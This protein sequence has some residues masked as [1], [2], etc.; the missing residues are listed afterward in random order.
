MDRY[1]A[2]PPSFEIELLEDCSGRPELLN[3]RLYWLHSA[4]KRPGSGEPP[5]LELTSAS[6]DGRDRKVIADLLNSPDWLPEGRLLGAHWGRAYCLLTRQPRQGKQSLPTL[7][8]VT[9]TQV[10]RIATLPVDAGPTWFEDGYLY[11][12]RMESRENWFNWSSTGLI[13]KTVRV[14][15]R[16]RLPA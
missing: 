7:C 11:Y 14:L 4:P 5:R 1:V 13:L 6:V 9:E 16:L 2:L 12:T 15:Y 10:T 8:E 3:G